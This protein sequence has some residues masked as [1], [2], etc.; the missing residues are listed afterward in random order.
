[1]TSYL[2]LWSTARCL[3]AHAY[4][5]QVTRCNIFGGSVNHAA[6]FKLEHKPTIGECKV[7]PRNT[8]SFAKLNVNRILKWYS[9]LPLH[10]PCT[11]GVKLRPPAFLGFRGVLPSKTN[12][13]TY[14]C[15]PSTHD[16][17]SLPSI[18]QLGVERRCDVA[19]IAVALMGVQRTPR[20]GDSM[21]AQSGMGLTP[22]LPCAMLV[23]APLDCT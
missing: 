23:S 20:R 17:V 11:R 6:D 5:Q 4:L 2:A 3:A 22:S 1:V 12:I 8:I 21:Q 19:T 10:F 15:R 16:P 14:I 13:G 7:C 9:L 18:T